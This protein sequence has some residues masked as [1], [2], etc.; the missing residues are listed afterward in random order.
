MRGG[1]PPLLLYTFVTHIE[2]SVLSYL[3]NGVPIDHAQF[4]CCQNR[5]KIMVR[6]QHNKV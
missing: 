6:T 2:R 3:S 4:L 5:G 1:I